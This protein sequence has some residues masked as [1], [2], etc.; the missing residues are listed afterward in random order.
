MKTKSIPNLKTASELYGDLEA[1]I[2][3]LEQ[4]KANK[5]AVEAELMALFNSRLESAYKQKDEPFGT[6]NFEE[7]GLKVTFNT[8]KKVE[9]NQEKLKALYEEGAPVE[10][11]FNVK[12]VVYKSFDKDTQK[13]F[14]P[15]RTVSPGSVT[16]K[17]E[18][19]K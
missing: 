3:A 19:L 8:P 9:W 1:A 10:V 17:V 12:E 7:D 18:E 6:V 2:N 4:A 13:Y 5:K 14:T 11:E 15:A 16:V